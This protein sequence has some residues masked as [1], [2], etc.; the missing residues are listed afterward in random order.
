MS[1]AAAGGSNRL[2][3]ELIIRRDFIRLLTDTQIYVDEIAATQ[4]RDLNDSP[5]VQWAEI[6]Q[7]C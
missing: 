7:K 5:E 2:L 3:R 6:I 1:N 4:I